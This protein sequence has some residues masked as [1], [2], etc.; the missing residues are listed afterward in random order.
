MSP[1]TTL[2][3]SLFDSGSQKSLVPR[4]SPLCCGRRGVAASFIEAA[5]LR[6]YR[7]GP[8]AK[9]CLYSVFSSL[10]EAVWGAKH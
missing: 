8:E 6:S 7:D 2:R 9:A 5:G 10:P 4:E 3:F 1:Q